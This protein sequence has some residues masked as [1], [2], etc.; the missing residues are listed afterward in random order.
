MTGTLQ[1]QHRQ[2]DCSRYMVQQP[3]T[4]QQLEPPVTTVLFCMWYAAIV[5]DWSTIVTHWCMT[6]V[7]IVTDWCMTCAAIVTDWS[8]WST[9]VTYW[10]MTCAA[11]V[12]YW[13]MPWTYAA[14]VTY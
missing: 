1:R 12:T 9:I 10:C 14:I 13:C 3:P 5:T 8:K 2:A 7:V 6:C 11:I 4:I